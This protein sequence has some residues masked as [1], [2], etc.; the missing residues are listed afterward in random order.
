MQLT[1]LLNAGAA[2]A[3]AMMLAPIALRA[4]PTYG[5]LKQS[6][7]PS[8]PSMACGATAA[9]NSFV[10][11]QT[12]YPGIYGNDLV[13]IGPPGVMPAYNWEE[14]AA[15]ILELPEY[16]GCPCPNG[17]TIEQFIVGKQAYIDADAP[18]TTSFAAEIN[19]PWD[20][21]IDGPKPS[22]VTD[23]TPPTAS[24]IY[25]QQ[26]SGE[27]VELLLTTGSTGHYVTLTSFSKVDNGTGDMDFVNPVTGAPAI[28][29]YDIDNQPFAPVYSLEKDGFQTFV[30][31][32]YVDPTDNNPDLQARRTITSEVTAAVAESPIPEPS[33]FAVLLVL[34]LTLALMRK[35]L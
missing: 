35:M 22:Y 13:G 27:D 5:N 32:T 28:G 17:T 34:G 20:P 18:G 23:G 10:F 19:V 4:N 1:S 30:T 25:G 2:V 8:C 33:Y 21:T 7:V 24:F 29:G 26:S 3:F 31:V 6:D 9:V 14:F 15:S 11:L 12:A 16:M